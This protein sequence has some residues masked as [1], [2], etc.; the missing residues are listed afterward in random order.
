[1]SKLNFRLKMRK[2]AR[3]PKIKN[4]ARTQSLKVK[5]KSN[6]VKMN[7]R[8]TLASSQ[9][10]KAIRNYRHSLRKWVLP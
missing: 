9:S 4:A 8:L 6:R 10:K 1:M 2:S 7:S 3:T 5:I